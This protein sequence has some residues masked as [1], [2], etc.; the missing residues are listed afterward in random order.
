LKRPGEKEKSREIYIYIYIYITKKNV[1]KY[2]FVK[3]KAIT[4][5]KIYI[6]NTVPGNPVKTGYRNRGT[7]FLVFSNRN[8]NRDPGFPISGFPVSGFPVPVPGFF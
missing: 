5:N 4:K 8:R 7:R 1:K 3:C 6:F 2:I